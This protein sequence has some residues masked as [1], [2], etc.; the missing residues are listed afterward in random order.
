MLPKNP[1]SEG[2]DYH[3]LEFTAHK[4]TRFRGQPFANY[5][6]YRKEYSEG[7]SSL[8]EATEVEGREEGLSKSVSVY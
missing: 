7:E 8:C 3:L 2:D 4:H 5:R 6:R 1:G